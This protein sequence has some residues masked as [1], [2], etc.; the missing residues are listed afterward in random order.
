M[1][2]SIRQNGVKMANEPLKIQQPLQSS[3]EMDKLPCTMN[4]EHSPV[5]KITVKVELRSFFSRSL[6]DGEFQ[7]IEPW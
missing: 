6:S 3:S 4:T 2:N 1:S 5:T 7:L